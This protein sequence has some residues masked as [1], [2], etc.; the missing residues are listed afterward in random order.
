VISGHELEENCALLSYYA[1]VVAVPFR[2]FG[3]TYRSHI[4][5]SSSPI[6]DCLNLKDGTDRLSQNVGK[7]LSL[8]AAQQPRTAR[9]SASVSDV[10]SF[11]AIAVYSIDFAAGKFGFSKEKR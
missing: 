4:Q 3:T 6:K 11:P 10:R 7:E 5:G 9:F 2:S 1:D 8:L